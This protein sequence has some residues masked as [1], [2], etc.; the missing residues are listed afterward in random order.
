MARTFVL[1]PSA[2]TIKLAGYSYTDGADTKV[3]EV[4]APGEGFLPSYTVFAENISTA[5][6]NSHLL[7]IMGSAA[8]RTR[9]RRIRI[10]Q[11]V[12]ATTAAFGVI[13]FFRLSTA[14]TGGTAITP[15]SMDFNNAVASA[16]AMTLPTVKGT[17]QVEWWAETPWFVGATTATPLVLMEWVALPIQQPMTIDLS[18]AK[19]IAIKM[20]TATAGAAVDI[21]V[22]L[23]ES[24][25]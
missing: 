10:R 13:Q 20:V 2:G 19:G 18:V 5:T 8:L 9:V 12:A 4:S 21:M 14:G 17:E 3:D 24:P 11:R 23:A 6:A 1:V 25:Y 22:D 15:S 7:Q 16:T